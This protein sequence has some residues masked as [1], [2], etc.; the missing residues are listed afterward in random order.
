MTALVAVVT[1]SVENAA[2]GICYGG[3]RSG[4]AALPLPLFGKAGWA[5][6]YGAPT[7]TCDF[8]WLVSCWSKLEC[9]ASWLFSWV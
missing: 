6:C 9:I 8:N 7:M 3:C 5:C 1:G 2:A 4:V